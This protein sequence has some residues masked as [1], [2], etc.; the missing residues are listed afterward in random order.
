MDNRTAAAFRELMAKFNE[1]RAKWIAA[2]GTDEGFNEWF[3]KQV[4]A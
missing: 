4:G 3:S 1:F 2:Y